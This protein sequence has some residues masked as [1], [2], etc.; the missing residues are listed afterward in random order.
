[1]NVRAEIGTTPSE[2]QRRR[3]KTAIFIMIAVAANSF[4]NLLLAEGMKRMPGFGHSALGHYLLHLL[5]N[6]FLIP[7]AALTALYTL[8]QLSLFSWAD[9]SYVV[10]CTASSY[11]VTT[12][13]G[14]FVLGEHI[15]P[16]RWAGVLLIFCGVVLVARTPTQ[17]KGPEE[18]PR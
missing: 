3:R 13:L 2:T 15:V 17:T 11:I 1:M 12:L 14:E 6:P 7:G 4:G 18:I 8:S 9:L 5:D 16:G 10:P